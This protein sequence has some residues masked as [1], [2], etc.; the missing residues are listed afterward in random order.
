MSEVV[1]LNLAL[2]IVPVVILEAS[3]EGISVAIKLNLALGTVPEDKFEALKFVIVFVEPLIDLLVNVSV[4]LELIGVIP[5][6]EVTS[7]LDN[8]TAP[9]LVLKEV[10]APEALNA[11]AFHPEP[12]QIYN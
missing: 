4:E 7:L 6:A 12:V 11:A 3:N 8:V 1:K 9:L 5:K 10:T 2:A